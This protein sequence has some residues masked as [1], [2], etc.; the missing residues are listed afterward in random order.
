MDVLQYWS[1]TLKWSDF[2]QGGVSDRAW[3]LF[4][5]MVQLSH[6][7]V[8]WAGAVRQARL[9]PPPS[10]SFPPETKS[11]R[12]RRLD[13]WKHDIQRLETH[14]HRAAYLAAEQ[15]A[16]LSYLISNDDEGKPDWKLYVALRLAVAHQPDH[17][18]GRYAAV[19]FTAFDAD[20]ELTADPAAAAIRWL[21]NAGLG[22]RAA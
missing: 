9:S 17:T 4:C 5:N 14:M 19:A 3:R 20:A 8:H 11:Q 2:R 22:N 10:Y 13:T 7:H 16:T 1:P 6:A 15:I 21:D 12:K 18:R